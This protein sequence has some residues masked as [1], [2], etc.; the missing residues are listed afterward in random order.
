MTPNAF[1][2]KYSKDITKDLAMRGSIETN[3]G[4]Q[5]RPPTVSEDSEPSDQDSPVKP[6]ATDSSDPEKSESNDSHE[7]DIGYHQGPKNAPR[8]QIAGGESEPK[9]SES[10]DAEGKDWDL[11]V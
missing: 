1:K 4:S 2:M 6:D 10:G 5:H 9:E 3:T 11:R 7:W 8:D